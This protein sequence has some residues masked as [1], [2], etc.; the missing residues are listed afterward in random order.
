MKVACLWSGGKD[1]VYACHLALSMGFEV[2]RL[3]TFFPQDP[4][5]ELLHV[6]N[7]RW[8]TLQAESIRLPQD[9]ISVPKNY[10]REVLHQTLLQLKSKLG[11]E[12]VVAGIIAS[13]YQKRILQ[14]VCDEIGLQLI[15][16]IW[17]RDQ[18]EVLHSIIREG[19]KAIIVGV[20][21]EGLTQQWLGREVDE[22][23]LNHL[24]RL[25]R[26]WGINPSGEGGEYETFVVDAPR[27]T[28]RVKVLDH[29]IVW[30]RNWGELIILNAT[31]IEKES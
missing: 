16:P 14:E 13:R 26:I 2:K 27:F 11:L 17:S 1:S 29:K 10:E 8:T 25:S 3:V 19:F 6:P 5:S 21:A 20:Y 4:E 30:Y 18:F 15:T 31:L 9:I 24:K 23:F 7:I 28:K 12:G 22:T